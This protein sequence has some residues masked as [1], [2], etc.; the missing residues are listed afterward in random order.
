MPGESM[1]R[2]NRFCL[3]TVAAL[4]AALLAVSLLPLSA[5]AAAGDSAAVPAGGHVVCIDAGHQSIRTSATEPIGPGAS[6]MKA[7]E[8]GGTQGR[9][10]GIPEYELNL[11]VSLKL[12]DILIQRGYTVVMTRET[13]AVNLSNIDRAAIAANAGADVFV[14]IHANGSD[15]ANANGAMT[16]CM[17]PNN[18]YN[19]R[20]HQS[21]RLLSDCILD[22]LVAATGCKREFVWET[23]TMTGINWATMPV[24]I[25]EMGYM[26]NER[27]DRLL[28]TDA[29][30][31]RVAS[32]IADGIDA[33]FDRTDPRSCD[34]PLITVDGGAVKMNAATPGA[35][36]RYT[37][38][39]APAASGTIYDPAN[40]PAAVK[41]TTYRA[42]ADAAGYRT[43]AEAMLT[44][45]G[46][47]FVMRDVAVSDWHYPALDRAMAEG[48]VNGVGGDML[49]PNA[50]VTR[51][52]LVTLLYRAVQ[53]EGT[54]PAAG[55][56]DADA[57]AY[58]AV[59]LNWAAAQG[60]VAGYPDGTFRPN[61]SITREELC[62]MTQR[63]LSA[64]GYENPGIDQLGGFADGASVSGW[65][66]DG[67]NLVCSLG[68]MKGYE[69]NT[70]R[71]QGTATRAEAVTMLLR[72]IDLPESAPRE[73]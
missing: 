37:T 60:I 67:V 61:Q 19:A 27:E 12:R 9:F 20:L 65:A 13:N 10:T 28:A 51:A 7:C 24:T 1:K 50:Q 73:A 59:P 25:V 36:V 33:Y 56:T 66:I 34:A 49:A 17:T 14:R 45:S 38:D 40:P 47:G 64:R 62:V 21:S 3:R 52:M 69:D 55:F 11:A 22:S 71:P 26:S 15:N 58:Y 18:P 70:I 35:V 16:L 23:D 43:S 8:S 29:Y 72:V 46:S 6:E 39:N 54:F 53:P 42:V 41:G 57:G 31:T 5:L 63:Y 44:Y 30:R 2:K 4:L 48:L 32:G 68:I